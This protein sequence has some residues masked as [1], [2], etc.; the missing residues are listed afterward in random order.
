MQKIEESSS[1]NMI[2]IQIEQ[3][4]GRETL[5]AI[6]SANFHEDLF[7][8]LGFVLVL[9]ITTVAGIYG[10]KPIESQSTTNK[11]TSQMRIG[12]K[13][14]ISELQEVSLTITNISTYNRFLKFSFLFRKKDNDKEIRTKLS[15]QF[16]IVFFK[17]DKQVNTARFDSG[18]APIV[19]AKNSYVSNE[20]PLFKAN[21]LD[22]DQV[23]FISTFNTPE[24]FDSC[25]LIE[26]HGFS[27]HTLFQIFF[28]SIFALIEISFFVLFA[29]RLSSVPFK[30]WHLEQQLTAPLVILC[31]LYNNPLTYFT[32][33]HP[34]HWANVANTFFST[35]FT[36]YFRLFILVLFDSLRYKNRKT[37]KCFFLPKVLYSI[38]TFMMLL[39]SEMH[40][41]S[42]S[43]TVENIENSTTKE[44]IRFIN[45]LLFT[46]YLVWCS[47]SIIIA[48]LKVDVTERY[49][50]SI[51][52]VA[53]ASALILLAVSDVLFNFFGFFSESSL[54][55][56]EDYA[57]QNVF[58]MLMI[59][60]HWPYEVLQDQT[61]MDGEEVN[62]VDQGDFFAQPENEQ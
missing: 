36:V 54:G 2:D 21:V 16:R 18:S 12:S 22:F 4:L 50:F 57:I 7:S 11:F 53:G 45:T 44:T 19:A 32:V 26:T 49:K 8:I 62:N 23:Q 43:Y 14:T 5:M 39:Y 9:I 10:P 60:F 33:T 24:G 61:Y 48:F 41:N 6:D 29:L 30:L 56:I 55:F 40:S 46:V 34:T 17:N 15:Y 20:I 35:L 1:G 58:V 59:Y 37:D 42:S 47:I 3:S 52:A 31:I 25:E 13:P 28:K 38:I 27:Q 51:Y